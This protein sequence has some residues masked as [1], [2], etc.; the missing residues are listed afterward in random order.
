MRASRIVAGAAV[1]GAAA[2]GILAF[3][4]VPQPGD[5]MLKTDDI[6]LA[7]LDQIPAADWQALAQQRIFFGHH[8]VGADIL[9]GVAAI[10]AARPQLRLRV[11][12]GGPDA[13]AAEPGLA[14]AAVGANGDPLGKL[15]DF[16]DTVGGARV[17]GAAALD[18]AAMKF[19]YVD[20]DRRTDVEALFAQ[21]RDAM[22]KLQAV[23]PG[24]RLLHCTVPLRAPRDTWKERVKR[25]LGQG[26]GADN[27]QREAFNAKLR[28][29]Y[30]GKQAL[31]DIA[32]AESTLP[33]GSRVEA[34]GAPCLAACYTRDGGHLNEVGQRALAREFLR[35]LAGVAR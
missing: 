17:G 33:D 1:L 5:L 16:V 32:A 34:D 3:A 11:V 15:R 4:A 31:F 27:Q 2:L 14:E 29:E 30:G 6:P 28:A 19:C 9:A 10:A 26:V 13:V 12:A 8:S 18:V 24:L 21:Y 7:A 25:L 35:V 22:A 20:V 23:L